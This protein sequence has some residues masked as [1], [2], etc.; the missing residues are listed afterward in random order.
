VNLFVH[1]IKYFFFYY[2]LYRWFNKEKWVDI[3]RKNK[4]G[5]HP[6][7]GASAGKGKRKGKGKHFKAYPKCRPAAQAAQMSDKEKKNAT[8]RK[9]K[10]V[11]KDKNK[12]TPTNTK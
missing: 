6:A 7:C 5:S 10:A 1:H 12:S 11:K 8:A 4:D 3:S 2:G 9:R